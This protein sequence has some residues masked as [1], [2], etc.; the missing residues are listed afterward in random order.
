MDWQEVIRQNATTIAAAERR[1]MDEPPLREGSAAHQAA[2]SALRCLESLCE[3]EANDPDI[4][5]YLW[6]NRA[7]ALRLCGPQHD[8][9]AQDAFGRA[10]AL[11]PERGWWWYDLGLLHKWRGRFSQGLDCNL[12]A[13]A[14]VGDEKRVLW[15]LAIC[16]TATGDGDLAAGVWAQLGMTAAVDATS[17][18]PFVDGL[19]PMFLRVLSRGTGYAGSLLPDRSTG[20]ELVSIAPL[21]PCHGVVQT[22]TFRDAPLD[23]GD[24][25]LWDGAPVATRPDGQPIF[26]VLE[27]LRRGEERR[28]PFVGLHTTG[29]EIETLREE[30][31][32]NARLFV[33]REHLELSCPRCAQGETLHD[34][35][36]PKDRLIYGKVVA[37]STT[38]LEHLRSQWDRAQRRHALAFAAPALYEALGDTKRAGQA[39]QA[40]LGIERKG[41]A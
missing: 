8:E 33:Q 2:S 7:N 37:P 35:A 1:G 30:L 28:F 10:L 41:G 23:Y 36:P 15:N 27:V 34:H 19:P 18:M 24:V 3:A 12:K 17:G 11:D 26:A 22:P 13:R 9:A 40:W 14:R 20:F 5:G 38:T 4:G 16:A 6:I 21:S 25:V 39:H 31:A 32:P 29:H